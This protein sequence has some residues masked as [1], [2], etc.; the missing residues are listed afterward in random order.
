MPAIRARIS[1]TKASARQC[2]EDAAYIEHLV[3]DRPRPARG[4][5]KPPQVKP[6]CG[7]SKQPFM[8]FGERSGLAAGDGCAR[9][10][11]GISS[12]AN[13]RWRWPRP[14]RA[15]H[16]TNADQQGGRAF[17]RQGR[18]PQAIVKLVKPVL[19]RPT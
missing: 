15:R 18:E 19:D 8:A 13:W 11:C 3:F 10:A 14:V 6:L 12:D 17:P 16:P 9:M 4:G 1:F 2:T 7:Q 5:E